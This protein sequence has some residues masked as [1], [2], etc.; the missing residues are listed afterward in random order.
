MKTK[1]DQI[2][3]LSLEQVDRIGIRTEFEVTDESI[4]QFMQ[5]SKHLARLATGKYTPVFYRFFQ[6][7]EEETKFILFEEWASVQDFLNPDYQNYRNSFLELTEGKNVLKTVVYRGISQKQETNNPADLSS[8][9]SVTATAPTAQKT[10]ERLEQVNMEKLPFVLF[11]DVPIKDEGIQMT[12]KAVAHIQEETWKEDRSIHYG[13]FQDVEN[14][15][16]FLL[17]EWWTGFD[18]M[19]AHLALPHFELLMKTFG[20]YGGDGRVVNL[21]RPLEY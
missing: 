3:A 10:I 16:S 13:Y 18:A 17:F 19:N 5:A 12:R 11:V 2:V 9:D 6:N 4:E 8:L 20:A 7:A 1:E 14:P 21:F 15:G